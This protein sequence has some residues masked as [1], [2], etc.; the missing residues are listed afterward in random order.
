MGIVFLILLSSYVLLLIGISLIGIRIYK[1]LS[2]D[3]QTL[4]KFLRSE[5]SVLNEQTKQALERF[6]QVVETK[7][8]QDDANAKIIKALDTSLASM[9]VAIIK[10]NEI[11][12]RK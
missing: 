3:R 4:S 10:L 1:I 7:S 5:V 9:A 12:E 11:L 8:H 2:L 6:K